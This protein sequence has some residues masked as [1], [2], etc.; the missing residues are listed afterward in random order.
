VHEAVASQRRLV[1]VLG[2]V[3]AIGPLS[4]DTY[5]PAFP[6]MA[7]ALDAS[8]SSVQ[9]TL[10]ACLAGLALGQ[11][12]AGSL[13]DRLGRRRPIL[14][15]LTGYV[16]ASL[17]CAVAPDVLTL[18]ALRFV[19]GFAGAAGLVIAQA[20]VRD[21]HSGA[22]AVRLFSSLMLIIG[23]A[24]ILA[25]VLGGQLLELGSWR[26]IFVA[27]AV[28][29]ALVGLAV[30]MQL[31]ETLP[32][33]RRDR[34]GLRQTLRTLRGLLGLR[35][36][37]GYAI[38]S[39]LCFATVF[40]YVSGSS[41]VLQDIYGASPQL[42]SVIFG[43]NGIGLIAASQINARL[44]ERVDSVTLLR[45]A[46]ECIAG[47]TLALLAV[48]VAGGL[49]AWAVMVPLFVIVCSFAFALP[50]ATALALADHPEVAGAASALLGV[51]Q[52]ISGAAVAPLVGIAGT[53][54]A[55]PMGIVM[56]ALGVS[57]LATVR[58]LVPAPGGAS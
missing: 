28:I 51:I 37:M 45:R 25:P 23:V 34:R 57:A 41:F 7:R 8:A 17:L 16:A 20:V 44:V 31:P 18:T 40:A 53:D 46:I 55:V 58:I 52:F 42:Y 38:T 12:V 48:V 11:L 9:L 21:L 19:Q 29:G 54:T 27:L 56:A 14:V 43:V 49:G 50:N 3:V 4:V 30:A 2:S 6:S 33:H 5:L 1:V 26:G 24:P 22:A 32:S 35:D 47:A 10:T 39:S 15:G 13:S 36:F